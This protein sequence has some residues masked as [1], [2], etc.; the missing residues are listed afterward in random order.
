MLHGPSDG[1]CSALERPERGLGP[2]PPCAGRPR[3]YRL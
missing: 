3:L 2:Q 1:T